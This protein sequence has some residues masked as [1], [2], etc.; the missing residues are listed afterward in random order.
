M[1]I[2]GVGSVTRLTNISGTTISHCLGNNCVS[3]SGTRHVGQTV[4][5]ANC[6]QS[7][8]THTLHANSAGL[9][10]IVIPGVGSR[11]ID[12]VATNV[13]RILSQ[14]NCRVL[15]TG[16]SGAPTHRL[17]CLSLF[18]GRPISN[19]ILMTAGVASRRHHT[20][21][22]YHI[23]V[24]LVNRGIRN[25][26]YICRSSCR[27]TCRLNRTLTKHIRNEVTCVNIARRSHT[28]NCS[29]HH[30][31][32]T[33]LLTTNIMLGPSLVHR[34]SFALSSNC[35]TTHRLL[36]SIPSI[37]FV[38]YTA[39]AVTTNTLHTF[40]RALNLNRNTRHIDNFNSGTFLHTLANNVPAIRCNC[41]AD[42]IRTAGVLLSALSNIRK[43]NN[44]QALGL[45]RRLVGI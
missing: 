20:V 37:S 19:V 9:V 38:T 23:P 29:H 5:R 13:N 27:T 32:R 17:R 24:I 43:R 18:R 26:T 8:R 41:L 10:N 34:K 14:H 45:N 33:N 16:A 31:F 21:R 35:H 44:L 12:H 11:S 30:N 3:T 7:G 25:T 15:L 1:L 4:R 28:T 36:I 2:T 39:S 6:I 40:S 22:S 42:N